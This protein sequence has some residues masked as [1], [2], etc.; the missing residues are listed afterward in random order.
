MEVWLLNAA[1][2]KAVPGRKTDVRDAE[3]IAQLLEHGLLKPS[4]V[5]PP[6]IRQLRML[7][8]Y[9]EQLQG[10]RTR[11][12]VRLELMLEDASIKLSTVASSLNTVSARV[13]LAAMVEGETDARVLAE[14]AKGRMRSKIP[15]LAQALEGHFNA[16]HAQLARS[17]L[18]RMDRVRQALAEVDAT[19]EV[20]CEPWAHQLE[21]LQTIR[22]GMEA[23]AWCT[24]G[25][26][27][28]APSPGR[29]LWAGYVTTR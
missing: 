14:M 21:L 27:G 17:I 24:M 15:D 6:A 10:D 7:T 11:E 20:A 2:M 19:M 23:P 26:V 8:R 22:G 12:T 4:F 28:T 3:W 29:A 18:E 25:S 1:H 13:M 9:R 5:P 16:H